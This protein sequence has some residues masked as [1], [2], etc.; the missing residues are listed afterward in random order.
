MNLEEAKK[1]L[2]N[3]DRYELRDHAFGDIEVT[4]I[5]NGDAVAGG[6]FGGRQASVWI[7]S[8][9]HVAFDDDEARQLQ[10]CG[11][12][13]TVERNDETGPAVFHAGVAMP[14]LTSEGVFEELTGDE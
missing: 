10:S 2:E 9:S 1:F 6:Y 11:T 4:W 13:T 14:G 3:T 12:L 8:E 5:L 7:D